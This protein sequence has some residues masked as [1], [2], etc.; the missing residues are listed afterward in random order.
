MQHGLHN[1]EHSRPSKGH[2]EVNTRAVGLEATCA[3]LHSRISAFLHEET[4]DPLLKSVQR[5]TQIS[6]DVAR[7]ALTRYSLDELC[8]S[9][10]GGKDCLVLLVIYL[11]ALHTHW[12]SS[13]TGLKDIT[14]GTSLSSASAND[15]KQHIT[16]PNRLKSVYIK[17]A[18]PFD[19]VTEFVES[20]AAEYH[21]DLL[22]SSLPMKAAFAHYLQQHTEVKAIFVG[23]R[24][25]D[26]HGGKLT[27]F[28]PTDRG[29][30]AFMRIHPVID[31]HYKEIWAFIRHLGIPYCSLYDLGYTSL[32]GTTDTH[33]NPMLLK[34]ST[35]EPREGKYFRPAYEL[36]EDDEERL[37]R[38]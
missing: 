24:R 10:N 15:I 12:N 14:N 7:D 26:P 31:W 38:A 33:P 23:T 9:Y 35:S 2:S 13:S 20:S 34:A 6:L 30:P 21:L 18:Y 22:S 5:Q 8:M 36:Q 32:G 27:H 29:W 19:E 25:T 4:S 16:F 37:G 1:G 3:N 17:P 28:D 11:A